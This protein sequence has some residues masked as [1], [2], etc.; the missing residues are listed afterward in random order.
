MEVKEVYGIH[1]YKELLPLLGYEI[2]I[3]RNYTD[4]K[5]KF[6]NVL[7]PRHEEQMDTYR[8]VEYNDKI[9]GN[10]YVPGVFKGKLVNRTLSE[11]IR[12]ESPNEYASFLKI[13]DQE[14]YRE[15]LNADDS[16]KFKFDSSF[17]SY[18]K[19]PVVS[20]QVH[21]APMAQ[22][23][24][25]QCYGKKAW[26]FWKSH[27]LVQHGIYPEATPHGVLLN[28][29][30]DSIVKTPTYRAVVNP[31]DLLYFPPFYYHAVASSSGKNVMFA[32]RKVDLKS[33]KMSLSINLKGT[34]FFLLRKTYH[35]I[36]SKSQRNKI[37]FI[38]TDDS[39]GFKNVFYNFFIKQREKAF[40]SFDGF[41]DFNL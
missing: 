26:L 14:D 7:Y 1:E 23:L 41:S 8:E 18:F 28:G 4:C 37:G 17:I 3:F 12:N 2:V 25:V 33:F 22:T 30:P 13:F 31:N 29:S 15:I 10:A 39:M 38:E 36:Q 27:E 35:F 24:S 6:D 9:Q 20:T 16:H 5:Q 40:G 19:R 32:I 34:I 11:T 21:A